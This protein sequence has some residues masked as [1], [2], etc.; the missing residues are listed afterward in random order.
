[1][2]WQNGVATHLT[3]ATLDC[4]AW[5][6]GVAVSGGNVFAVGWEGSDCHGHLGAVL[7]KNGAAV[8]LT[9]GWNDSANAVT[10]SGSDVYV[11]GASNGAAVLWKNGA[12]VPLADGTRANAVAVSGSDVY[13]AGSRGDDA[14]LWKNGVATLLAGGTSA[15]AVALSGNDV[16]VAGASPKAAMVWKNGV[17]IPLTDGATTARAN[18]IVVIRR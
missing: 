6:S 5:A 8:P 17:A 4:S 10:V 2:L 9:D 14:V 16:Y 13:V 18:S 12:P 11:A 1:M 15:N 3:R 7:W